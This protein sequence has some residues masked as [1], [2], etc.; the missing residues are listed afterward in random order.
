MGTV[1]NETGQYQL[2]NVQ[3]GT[4]TV[5]V[6]CPGLRLVNNYTFIG[7]NNSLIMQTGLPKNIGTFF[8]YSR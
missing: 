7:L 6:S 1:T 3:V 2:I 8:L 5:T 4:L